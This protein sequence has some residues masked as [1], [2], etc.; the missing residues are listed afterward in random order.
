MKYILTLLILALTSCHTVQPLCRHIVISQYLAY[1]DQ[2]EC[3]IVAMQNENPYPYPKHLAVR[4]KTNNGWQWISQDITFS[5]GPKPQAREIRTITLE[6][7]L[8]IAGAK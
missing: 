1:R 3:E 5:T 7:A 4:I 2:Y 8:K 6:E